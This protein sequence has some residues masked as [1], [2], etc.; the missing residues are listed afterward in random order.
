MALQKDRTPTNLLPG[1]KCSVCIALTT[2]DADDR[3]TLQ[4]WLD[5]PLVRSLQL[6]QWLNDDGIGYIGQQAVQR[7]RRGACSGRARG[8]V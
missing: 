4:D 5:N 2:M 8:L 6:V 1:P 7:H 3:I